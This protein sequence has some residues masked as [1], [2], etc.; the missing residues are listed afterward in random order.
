MLNIFIKNPDEKVTVNH[1]DGDKS[2]N[3]I[4]NLEWMSYSENMQH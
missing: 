2:N 1:I 3:K 4:D